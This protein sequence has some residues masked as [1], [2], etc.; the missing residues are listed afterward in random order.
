MIA[1]WG[2]FKAVEPLREGVPSKAGVDFRWALT[3]RML[4]GRTDVWARLVAKGFQD[5]DLKDGPAETAVCLNIRSW[6][7]L[8]IP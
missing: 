5:P 7:L 3:R 2:R 6:H 1:S 4:G 8:V